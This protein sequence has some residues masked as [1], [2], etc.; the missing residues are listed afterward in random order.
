[1]LAGEP[2]FTGPTMQAIVAR[3][4][5]ERVR[6]LRIVRPDAPASVEAA[7]EEALAKDPDA[8]PPSAGE[9]ARRL[10]RDA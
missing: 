2:P 7:I 10:D 3:Q 9:F 4:A 8:R 5:G 1:M 6:R